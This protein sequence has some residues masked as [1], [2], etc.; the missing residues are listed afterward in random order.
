MKKYNRDVHP[1]Y[2]VEDLKKVRARWLGSPEP[3][4]ASFEDTATVKDVLEEFGFT[5]GDTAKCI[6]I[7]GTSEKKLDD[8]PDDKDDIFLVPRVEMIDFCIED[9]TLNIDNMDIEKEKKELEEA[10][11]KIKEYIQATKPD[12]WDEKLDTVFRTLVLD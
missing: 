9:L 12:L 1:V 5:I 10:W 6:I 3:V 4:F 8:I 2:G 7:I 11:N